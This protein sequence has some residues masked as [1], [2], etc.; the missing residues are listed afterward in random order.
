MRSDA[1][2]GDFAKALF[3]A[4]LQLDVT[5]KKQAPSARSNQFLLRGDR[6]S[7]LGHEDQ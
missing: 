4:E 7:G 3:L 1:H 6:S 5:V 2:S